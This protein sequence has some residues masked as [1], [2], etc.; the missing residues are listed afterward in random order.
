MLLT[1]VAGNL[2]DF[3]CGKCTAACADLIDLKKL[4]GSS[5]TWYY[6]CT[7]ELLIQIVRLIS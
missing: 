1:T 2:T 7:A 4:V 5:L 6:I 3:Y